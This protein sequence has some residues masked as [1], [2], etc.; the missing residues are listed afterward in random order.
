[1]YFILLLLLTIPLSLSAQRYGLPGIQNFSRAEYKGGT[2]NWAVAQGENGMMYFANN[3]GLLEF[4]GSHWNIYKDLGLVN[5]SVCVDKDRIYIGA[6]NNFGFYEKSKNGTLKYHSL[7]PL[8]KNRINDFDEIW[9]IHKTSF[10]IVFQSFRA[11]FIYHDNKIDIVYPR[12]KFHF[13][14]YVNGVLWIYD[15]QEGLMQYREGKVRQVPDGNFFSGTEIWTILPFI[16]GKIEA[17]DF[18]VNNGL[19]FETTTD[20]GGGQNAG[21]T[22]AG[23]YLEYKVQVKR[24]ATYKVDVRAACFEKAGRIEMQ[25]LDYNGQVLHSKTIEIPVTGGWQNWVTIK[26]EM[27]MDAG[28][29]KLRVNILQP[30][31]NLNWYNFVE[32]IKD[33]TTGNNNKSIRIF[34]NPAKDEL[35]IEVPKSKG[36][37]NT[38]LIH[39]L[40][41]ALVKTETLQSGLETYKSNIGNLNRG[42]YIVELL[43]DGDSWRSKLLIE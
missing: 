29:S 16:G 24:T 37:A 13:S 23:D 21:F 8:L 27:P 35:T 28:L 9:R 17:E 31:F 36:K 10:G 30:E 42:F 40:N 43:M 38:L 12:S 19:Q 25:Q 5:R 34:P 15:E 32:I 18:S 4:D 22:N 33:T 39:S 14:Y 11:I 20:V 6:F 7:L 26:S 41:G 3:Y 2:Q 1:M